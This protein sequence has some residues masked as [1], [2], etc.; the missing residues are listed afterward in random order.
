[1]IRDRDAKFTAAFDA[2]LAAIAES[3]ASVA[4]PTPRD[5]CTTAGPYGETGAKIALQPLVNLPG[6]S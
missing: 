4:A 6:G 5:A 3:A 1:M 2:V